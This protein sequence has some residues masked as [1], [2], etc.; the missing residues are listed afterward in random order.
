[1]T[2]VHEF[3]GPLKPVLQ[4]RV[5]RDDENEQTFFH[6]KIEVAGNEFGL[7]FVIPDAIPEQVPGMEHELR[8][9][10]AAAQIGS[11][12]KPWILDMITKNAR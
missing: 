7:D 5:R 3:G 2:D 1:M 10:Q 4:R 11:L 12:L 8:A 6:I 9:E